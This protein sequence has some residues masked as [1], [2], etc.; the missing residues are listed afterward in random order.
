MS[1]PYSVLGLPPDS[2]DDAIRRRYLELVKQ[3]PPGQSPERFAAVREAYDRLRDLP[4]RV[5]SRL[6]GGED[7]EAIDKV[8]EEL[9]CQKSRR[10]VSLKTLL[11]LVRRA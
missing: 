11:S 8:I 2:D 7:G 1:D 10:R 3:F 4:T 6:F 9:A 5:R